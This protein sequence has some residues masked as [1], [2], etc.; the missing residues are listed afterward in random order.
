MEIRKNYFDFYNPEERKIIIEDWEKSGL[1]MSTYCR[2]KRIPIGSFYEWRCKF[3]PSSCTN[4][5]Q[6]RDKWKKHI[7]D[8]KKSGLSKH[9]YCKE[10]ELSRSDISRWEKRLDPSVSRKTALEKW[11]EIV[12]DWKKSG[13]EKSVYCRR[14]KLNPTSFYVWEKKLN[15]SEPPQRLSDL[16]EESQSQ[17]ERSL[18]DSF[19]P[20]EVI[21]RESFS[22][23]S[24]VDVILSQGHHLS[25]EDSFDW[26]TLRGGLMPLLTKET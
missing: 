26:K 14:K 6:I 19:T 18:K 10:K 8:W 5:K 21:S 11:T 13:L 15:S 9:A 2:Q 16:T 22:S 25:L 1:N 23:H 17:F 4:L 3:T 20:L 24:K 7:E 12:E